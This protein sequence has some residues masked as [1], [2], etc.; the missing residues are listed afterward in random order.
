MSERTNC[1][2]NFWRFQLLLSEGR[3]NRRCRTQIREK[4]ALQTAKKI[5]VTAFATKKLEGTIVHIE[6]SHGKKHFLI[7]KRRYQLI[8]AN[9]R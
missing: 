3:K 2:H 9:R 7:A 6:R 4:F 1:K 8:I 5:I